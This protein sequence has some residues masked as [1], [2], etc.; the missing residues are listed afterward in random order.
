MVCFSPDDQYML[1]SGTDNDIALIET[2]TGAHGPPLHLCRTFRTNNYCRSYFLSGAQ[3]CVVGRSRQRVVSV[4]HTDGRGVARELDVAL[5]LHAH[6]THRPV[7]AVSGIGAPSYVQSLRG[8][9]SVELQLG[10]LVKSQFFRSTIVEYDLAKS[11]I[12]QP[13]ALL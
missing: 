1:A 10:V 4:V 8:H 9:P 6:H 5:A 7:C 12:A 2:S 3:Y 13:N 11:A